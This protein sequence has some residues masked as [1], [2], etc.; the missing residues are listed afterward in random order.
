MSVT[1]TLFPK[2]DYHFFYSFLLVMSEE[3]IQKLR[4]VMI[5]IE[6]LSVFSDNEIEELEKKSGKKN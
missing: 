3:Q 2:T 1:A 4:R 5:G 6:K